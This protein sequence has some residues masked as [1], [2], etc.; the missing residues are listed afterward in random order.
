MHI[1][2]IEVR[3]TYETGD[4][5]SLSI[6]LGCFTSAVLDLE[7]LG[8]IGPTL[9]VDGHCKID[10]GVAPV[11]GVVESVSVLGLRVDPPLVAVTTGAKAIAR[12][13]T[14][15]LCDIHGVDTGA[16]RRNNA[17]SLESAGEDE[18]LQLSVKGAGLDGKRG[19]DALRETTLSASS[20]EEL[21]VTLNRLDT[22]E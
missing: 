6:E 12:D 1:N 15:V 21:V 18:E 10:V 13:G 7:N 2:F 4:T 19:G 9:I 14:S 8:E 3:S 22:I 17:V 20:K 5:E 11:V 16:S